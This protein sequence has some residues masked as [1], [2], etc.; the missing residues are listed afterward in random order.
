MPVVALISGR[1]SNMQALL[2]AGIPLAAVISNRADAKGLAIAA[3][4]DVPTAVVE[5]RA[6]ATREA[7]DAALA[8]EIDRYAPRLVVLAGFM[9]ILTP[10]FVERYAGRLMNIHPS[11]LPDFPGLDTHARALAAG[12]KRHGCTVH[13]VTSELDHGPIVIQAEVPVLPGDTADA[14]EARVLREEHVI[15][16][17]AV[18]W[19]LDGRLD[20]RDG[21]VRVKGGDAQLVTAPR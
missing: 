4:R 5:H 16:P 7:F 8:A 15:Y 17:R 19:F 2:D 13:F 1:G 21:K 11:L 10:R 14:L 12:A 6:Y 9:R 3:A 20:L 18:K